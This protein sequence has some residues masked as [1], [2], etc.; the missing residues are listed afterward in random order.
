MAKTITIDGISK[1]KVTLGSILAVAMFVAPGVGAFIDA[2]HNAAD[3]RER[4]QDV[5]DL[6]DMLEQ[7]ISEQDTRYR[8]LEAKLGL[9][10]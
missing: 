1:R 5:E 3:S 7:E 9:A 2:R 4:L 8:V 10:D 6:V